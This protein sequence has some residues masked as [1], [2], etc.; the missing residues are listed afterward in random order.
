MIAISLI[1]EQPI[2]NLLPLLYLRPYMAILVYSDRTEK[3]T[4]RLQRL[5]GRHDIKTHTLCTDAYDIQ[6]IQANLQEFL[7]S[8]RLEKAE[9]I[10]NLTG[11]TKT[12]VIAAYK[13]AR[14]YKAPFFY[15]Q[16]EGKSSILYRYCFNEE[17]IRY[18]RKTLRSLLTIDDYLGAYL[19]DPYPQWTGPKDHFEQAIGEALK[20]AMDE[21]KVGVT[22][23][24]ALEVDL[25][26]RV[27]NQVGVIQA[28]TGGAALR[29]DG[30]NQLNAACEQRYLGTYTY[31]ILVINQRW[32][33]TRT[34]LL[35]LAEAWRIK[36]IEVPSFTDATPWL[37]I[38]DQEYLRKQVKQ[39]LSG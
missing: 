2:P 26:V 4:R 5:L 34:N 28:K 17:E 3:V 38:E 9:L 30:L 10:F 8:Q 29:K 7:T 22:L 19:D 37:S 39:V 12:M 31:K 6:K 18:E 15:L 20:E 27:N 33:D 14:K 23:A 25:V 36:V 24:P 32:D 13:L 11:G 35:E 21:V 16:S 1:G